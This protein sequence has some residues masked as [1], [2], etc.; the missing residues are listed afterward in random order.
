KSVFLSTVENTKTSDPINLKKGSYDV[1]ESS[2][3]EGWHLASVK[4]VYDNESIGDLIPLGGEHITV[5]NGNR[6][7]CTF[8]NTKRGTLIVKK[9]VVNDNGGKSAASD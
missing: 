1:L 2:F 7:T 8:M 6:V 9:V 3:S 5:N 4:C